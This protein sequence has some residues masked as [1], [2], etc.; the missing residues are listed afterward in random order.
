MMK[1]RVVNFLPFHSDMFIFYSL[2]YGDS[3]LL[4]YDAMFIGK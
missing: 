3:G 4:Q 1:G 2:E